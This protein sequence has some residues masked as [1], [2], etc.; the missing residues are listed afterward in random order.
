MTERFVRKGKFVLPESTLARPGVVIGEAGSGK[1]ETLLR[2]A[3]AAALVYG[4][5][6]LYLDAKGDRTTA[7][8]FLA[9]MWA[10]GKHCVKVF[11]CSPYYGWTGDADTLFNRLMAVQSYSEEYYK[12]IASLMINLALNFPGGPPRSGED[13]LEH[14]MLDQLFMDYRGCREERDLIR[15][16]GQ[17]ANGV[18]NRYRAFFKALKGRLD[19]G[20]TIDGIDAAY[21]LL[22]GIAFREETSSIG[23]FLMEDI[24][25]YVSRR[26]SPEKK[27]LIIV[28]EVSALAITNIVNLVERLR[29]FGGTVF[30]SSQSQEGL[31]A[32]QNER[33]RILGTAHTLILH[34]SNSPERIVIRAGKSKQ[35]SQRWN[36]L[37]RQSTGAG[38][39]QLLDDNM[40][41]PDNVRRLDVGE[42]YIIVKGYAQKVC[43]APVEITP[44]GLRGAF[45]FIEEEERATVTHRPD[46][47]STPLPVAGTPPNRAQERPAEPEGI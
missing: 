19:R 16:N 43:I 35:V 27:V 30:L 23:R 17:D 2:L 9:A 33:D 3:F 28:D 7:A 44:E 1:T 41:P 34:T 36:V 39:V 46:S 47:K 18:Y 14:L 42:A 13:F 31:A 37:N 20:F 6:V 8:R 12:W 45:Q 10:A 32:T 24:A 38:T 29:A 25:H 22:D 11:P 21:I 26:K 5:Y 4:Y 15:I 40:I